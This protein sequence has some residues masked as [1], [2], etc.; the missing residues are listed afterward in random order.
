MVRE[1]DV[2]ASEDNVVT[3]CLYARKRKEMERRKWMGRVDGRDEAVPQA[4]KGN[5]RGMERVG[6]NANPMEEVEEI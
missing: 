2:T 5:G 6:T 4:G 1:E 3:I